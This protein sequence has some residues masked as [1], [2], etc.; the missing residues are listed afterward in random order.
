LT[1]TVFHRP[2]TGQINV[3]QDALERLNTSIAFNATDL[4]LPAAVS[5]IHDRFFKVK[6]LLEFKARLVETSAKKLTQLYTKVVAEGSSG[7]TP[8]PGTEFTMTSF[9]S[10]LLP[11][12]SPVVAFLRTLP[13][14]ST[15]PSHPAAGAIL[16]TL[17]EA[18]QGYADMRG[19]WSVKCLEGQGKRLVVRA[20]TVDA[21]MTEREFREWVELMLG[22]AEVCFFLLSGQYSHNLS[23]ALYRTCNNTSHPSMAL[24]ASSDWHVV[25]YLLSFDLVRLISWSATDKSNP[26]SLSHALLVRTTMKLSHREDLLFTSTTVREALGI[27]RIRTLCPHSPARGYEALFGRLG[28]FCRFAMEW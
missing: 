27:F 2:Q 4:D 20:E 22:T 25:P 15:H 5:S 11:T 17:K 8:A 1:Y 6:V 13:L 24:R 26:V 21:L 14:P 9:P 19:N 3:Y 23:S 16:A 12:L 28:S 18:Q 10:S 7:T